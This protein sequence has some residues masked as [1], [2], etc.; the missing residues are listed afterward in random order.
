[1]C[2][3][4]ITC[5]S[6]TEGFPKSGHIY[7]GVISPPVPVSSKMLAV[8]PEQRTHWRQDSC[9]IGC[10]YLGNWLA[11]HTPS[12]EFINLIQTGAT[13]NQSA[14]FDLAYFEW[15]VIIG[16]KWRN[17][18]TICIKVLSSKFDLI[19]ICAHGFGLCLLSEVIFRQLSF[20]GVLAVCCPE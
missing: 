5:E 7:Q 16:T 3:A 15:A 12:Y 1:M 10:P 14:N 20:E 11:G 8:I 9:C 18:L 4:R 13:H 19:L 2:I 17:R 6:H